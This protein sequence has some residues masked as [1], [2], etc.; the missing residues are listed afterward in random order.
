[1]DEQDEFFPDD[2][3]LEDVFETQIQ[4]LLQIIINICD[5]HDI[6]MVAA[7][8]YAADGDSQHMTTSAIL[9]PNRTSVVL[10]NVVDTLIVSE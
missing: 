10:K 6:P 4:P 1:M 5:E 8:Q 9:P 2:Y 7:F 3:D